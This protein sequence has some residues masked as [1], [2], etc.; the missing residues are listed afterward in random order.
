MLL[1]FKCDNFKAFCDGFEFN[2]IPEKR[3]NELKYSLLTEK[4]GKREINALSSSVIYGPNA[5]GKTTIIT[6]MSCM[7]QIVLHGGVRDMGG[8]LMEGQVSVD[9]LIPF[10]FQENIRPVCFE[11]EFTFHGV[12]YR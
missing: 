10:A 11:S 5:A 7:R 12:Q 9:M 8:N 4:I 3:M 6:A 1:K 2:M